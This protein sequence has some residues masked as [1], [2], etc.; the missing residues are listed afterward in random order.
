MSERAKKIGRGVKGMYYPQNNYTYPQAY[1]QP[2]IALQGY[3]VPDERT[4]RE[5][6]VNTNG[7]ISVFPDI[8]NGKIYTKQLDMNSFNPI[9]KTY[10]LVEEQPQPLPGNYV[11]LEDFQQFI[12]N[13]QNILQKDVYSHFDKSLKD[14]IS[15][16]LYDMDKAGEIKR[17]KQGSTYQLSIIENKTP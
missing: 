3:P 11:S 13:H 2:Q 12:T 6:Q 15:K 9:F 8:Q 14:N 7:T 10:Q 17:V 4:A 1:G 5:A 16:M